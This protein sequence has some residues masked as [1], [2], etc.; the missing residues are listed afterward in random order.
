MNHNLQYNIN[1]M[2]SGLIITV[3]QNKIIDYQYHALIVKVVHHLQKTIP[4][5]IFHDHVW[6]PP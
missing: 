3:L 1:A 5:K 4:F 2:D 6:S